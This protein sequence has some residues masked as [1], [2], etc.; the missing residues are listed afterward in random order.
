MWFTF[1]NVSDYILE[2]DGKQSSIKMEQVGFS[3]F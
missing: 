3:N 2:I 1:W